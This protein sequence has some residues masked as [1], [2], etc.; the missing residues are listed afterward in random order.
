MVTLS[1]MVLPGDQIHFVG[2]SKDNKQYEVFKNKF[3]GQWQNRPTQDYHKD[4]IEMIKDIHSETGECPIY[5]IVHE[6]FEDAHSWS[7]HGFWGY[8]Q[9]FVSEYCCFG[10]IQ[11]KPDVYYKVKLENGPNSIHDDKERPGVYAKDWGIVVLLK[12]II[13]TT[14]PAPLELTKLEMIDDVTS[15]PPIVFE[16]KYYKEGTKEFD[17]MYKVVRKIKK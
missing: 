17:S 3:M 14:D 15:Y 12:R 11:Y 2:L 1:K 4:F 10:S 5:D 8:V 16:E 13:Y 6:E 7:D 9:K